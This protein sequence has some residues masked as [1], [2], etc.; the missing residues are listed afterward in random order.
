MIAEIDKDGAWHYTWMYITTGNIA[1][2]TTD[3]YMEVIEI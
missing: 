2:I 3:G 1:I